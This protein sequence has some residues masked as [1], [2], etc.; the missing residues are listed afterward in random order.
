MSQQELASERATLNAASKAALADGSRGVQIPA[1]FVVAGLIL[2]IFAVVAALVAIRFVS[3]H[4]IPALTE[5]ALDRAERLWERAG[6]KSYDMD[7]EIRGA[8]PGQVHIEVRNG[9]VTKMSRDGQVPRQ[10]T[11]YAWSVPGQFETLERELEMAEDPEHE[12]HATIGTKITV[13]SDFD[14][15][16][17]FPRRFH[18]HVSA[19]GPEVYWR[20]T[21]FTPR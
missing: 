9:E 14:P 15:T 18:R 2:A 7:L 21:G 17:G 8:R 19:G 13:R 1:R 5:A 4:R 16:F 3:L 12:M 11:W 10:H 6:P 20:V